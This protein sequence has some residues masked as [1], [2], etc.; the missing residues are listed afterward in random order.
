MRP[1]QR[2]R[3]DAFLELRVV[4]L[5]VAARPEHAKEGAHGQYRT[6]CPA[7]AEVFSRRGSSRRYAAARAFC[8]ASPGLR[9]MPLSDPH[10]PCAVQ[11]HDGVSVAKF[12]SRSPV[13]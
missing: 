1:K 3:G 8:V 4:A 5:A 9:S 12:V 10:G 6:D 2:I 7:L 13:V 11:T